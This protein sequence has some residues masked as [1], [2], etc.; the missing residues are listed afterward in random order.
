MGLPQLSSRVFGYAF[1]L[2]VYNCIYNVRC[3]SRIRMSR[4]SIRMDGV[5]RAACFLLSCFR[6]SLLV[7]SSSQQSALQAALVFAPGPSAYWSVIPRTD[8]LWQT[9]DDEGPERARRSVARTTMRQ[10]LPPSKAISQGKT[11]GKSLEHARVA[12]CPCR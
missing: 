1:S 11:F 7:L 9:E 5:A 12:C 8:T 4:F 3:T 2:F 10:T 6:L